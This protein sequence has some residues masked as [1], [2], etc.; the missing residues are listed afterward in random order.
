MRNK[1]TEALR[2]FKRYR[3]I[4]TRFEQNR[5]GREHIVLDQCA[6]IVLCQ[7][8][9][10]VLHSEAVLRALRLEGR[11]LASVLD[12]IAARLHKPVNFARVQ[13]YGKHLLGIAVHHIPKRG[14]TILPC[15]VFGV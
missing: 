14:L 11:I 6:Y 12:L 4:F 15:A 8:S 1:R 10:V 7:R 9:A 2:L 13:G 5:R 3:H